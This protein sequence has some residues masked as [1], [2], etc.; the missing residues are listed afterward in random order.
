MQHY[1]EVVSIEGKDLGCVALKDLKKGTLVLK[2][3]PQFVSVTESSG[4]WKK[5]SYS[6]VL[7]NFNSMSK[8]NQV[9]Y[10][11]LSNQFNELCVDKSKISTTENCEILEQIIGIYETNKFKGG[12]GIQASRFNHSCSSNAEGVWN[13]EE[14]TREFRVIKKISKGI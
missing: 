3:K 13:K 8:S 14:S 1:F 11:K 5:E 2:E 12:V 6:E 4:M 7:S 9:D 10:L